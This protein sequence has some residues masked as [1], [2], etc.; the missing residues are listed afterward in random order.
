MRRVFHKASE[1]VIHVLTWFS[2]DQNHI[3]TLDST[4]FPSSWECEVIIT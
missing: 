2:F 4:A 3:Q 1:D